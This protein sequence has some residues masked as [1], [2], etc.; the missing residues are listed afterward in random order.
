MPISAGALAFAVNHPPELLC[1]GEDIVTPRSG[2]RF[3]RLPSSEQHEHNLSP[4]I[5]IYL[6][7]TGASL[8]QFP[9]DPGQAAAGGFSI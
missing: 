3:Q 1:R 5:T 2:V 8:F 6:F 4:E 7:F 9:H